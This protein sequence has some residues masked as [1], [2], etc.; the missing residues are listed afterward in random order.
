[1]SESVTLIVDNLYAKA[2]EA[3]KSRI[4]LSASTSKLIPIPICEFLNRFRNI[5]NFYMIQYVEYYW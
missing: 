1:M 3:V 5:P 4:A 2:I